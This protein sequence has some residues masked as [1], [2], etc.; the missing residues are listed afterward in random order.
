MTHLWTRIA[1]GA[2]AL[3]LAT[4]IAAFAEE[5]HFAAALTSTESAHEGSGT[6]NLTVN[7]A[8]TAVFYQLKYTALDTRANVS[9]IRVTSGSQPRAA[10]VL[11]G[12]SGR[13]ECPAAGGQVSGVIT[14]ADI[15]PVP[16]ASLPA[17]DLSAFISLMQSGSTMAVVHDVDNDNGDIRGVIKQ[18]FD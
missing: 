4:S 2:S 7:E 8:G 16:S 1:C 5:A 10:V 14:A 17:H 11:C 15:R 3:L 9:T 18:V 12:A 6:V 13:P